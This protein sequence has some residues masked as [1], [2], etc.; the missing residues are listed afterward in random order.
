[1]MPNVKKRTL[2]SHLFAGFIPMFAEKNESI[3][4]FKLLE[5]LMLTIAHVAYETRQHENPSKHFSFV[6]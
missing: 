3:A 1:M 6:F 4:P 2:K 5:F